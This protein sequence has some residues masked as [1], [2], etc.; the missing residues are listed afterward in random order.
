MKRK[1]RQE[2]QDIYIYKFE[3]HGKRGDINIVNCKRNKRGDDRNEKEN[4]K[5]ERKIERER[6]KN[7]KKTK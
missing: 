2:G 1:I 5:N 7:E 6:R 4:Q 3:K